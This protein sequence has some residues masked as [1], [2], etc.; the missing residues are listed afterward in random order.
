MSAAG[1]AGPPALGSGAWYVVVAGVSDGALVP[2]L[3]FSR[4]VERRRA[5]FSLSCAA[6]S[7]AGEAACGT[8]SSGCSDGWLAATG[9]GCA[10]DGAGSGAPPSKSATAISASG[11]E[12]GAQLIADRSRKPILAISAATATAP[13]AT[14][15]AAARTPLATLIV[16]ALEA[17]LLLGLVLLGF[18]FLALNL[19]SRLGSN[20]FA[21]LALF[22][23]FTWLA[24]TASAA[25]P[26]ALS[27][28]VTAAFLLGFTIAGFAGFLGET[29]GFLG[30]HLRLELSIEAVVLIGI[31]LAMHRM[32]RGLRREQ[33]LRRLQRMNL[34]AAVDDV[35]LYAADIRIGRRRPG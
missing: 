30:L 13:A 3:T 29:L 33:R 15:A 1:S 25:P 32:S 22:A 21:V 16:A 4:T 23:R 12:G 14:A 27:A 34:L 2:K 24:T 9:S 10:I 35:G 8:C 28:T 20:R 19:V 11:G 7:G 31:G 18:A 5:A 26:A 17:G 6:S